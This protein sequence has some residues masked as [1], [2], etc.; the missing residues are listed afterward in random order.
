MKR[1]KYLALTSAVTLATAAVFAGTSAAGAL[2][3]F[4]DMNGDGKVTASDARII[5]RHAARLENIEDSLLPAADAD[6]DGRISASDAR[7]VLRYA[8]KLIDK[9]DGEE[10]YSKTADNS[11]SEKTT[12]EKPTSTTAEPTDEVTRPT[13][14][15]TNPTE[16]PT[17]T[18]TKNGEV[19]TNP[20]DEI[21][22]S[23]EKMYSEVLNTYRN[24]FANNYYPN[25]DKS[26]WEEDEFDIS[27][28]SP[29]IE[30]S[31]G[32]INSPLYYAYY[33]ISND[34]VPELIISLDSG[35]TNGE[36]IVDILGYENGEV[37]RLFALSTFAVRAEYSINTDGYIRFYG[38]GGAKY[39]GETYYQLGKNSATPTLI[40][41]FAFEFGNNTT[42]Y[43]SGSESDMYEITQEEYD[44]TVSKFG[45]FVNF[46]SNILCEIKLYES[47]FSVRGENGINSGYQ[48]LLVTN[49]TEDELTVVYRQVG[50]GKY[51]PVYLRPGTAFKVKKNGEKSNVK[52]TD[53]SGYEFIGTVS[54]EDG[55]FSLAYET[56]SPN[57]MVRQ[58]TGAIFELKN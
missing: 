8:A 58:C 25:E 28:F 16:N 12:T 37:K 55:Y 18:T 29:D 24:A 9:M 44:S 48:Q 36:H 23:Y 13:D 33:D 46:E 30:Q 52:W 35:Y 27:K 5:L 42:K 38:T 39:S 6:G 51:P 53:Q 47:E 50:N 45:E 31:F 54:Y 34:G 3:A 7:M 57:S 1:I 15:T 43:F 11:E 32:G 49:E 22:S 20:T 21:D 26:I 19:S 10:K 2:P 4:G 40:E 14:E 17:E 56:N 41:N